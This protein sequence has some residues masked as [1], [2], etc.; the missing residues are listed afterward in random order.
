[1]AEACTNEERGRLSHDMSYNWRYQLTCH[2]HNA[3]AGVS[4][5]ISTLVGMISTIA[6]MI[7]TISGMVLT[8]F[9]SYQQ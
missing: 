7:S 1:M 9:V 6:G 2:D 4:G 5:M 8:I 3:I